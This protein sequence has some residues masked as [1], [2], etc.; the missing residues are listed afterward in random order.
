[1]LGENKRVDLFT[2]AIG[3]LLEEDALDQ[4]LVNLRTGGRGGG[5]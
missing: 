3:G 1:L 4:D 2:Q 5:N